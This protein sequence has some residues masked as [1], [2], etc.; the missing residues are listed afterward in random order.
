MPTGRRRAAIAVV[1][2]LAGALSAVPMLRHPAAAGPSAAVVGT[3]IADGQGFWIAASDGSVYTEGDAP[4]YGSAGG[5]RLSKPIVGMAATKDARGYWLVASDGG[6]FSFGDARFYGSTGAIRLNQPI[7]GMTATPDG[8]GYWLV[9]SDGGI[10]S[11][12]DA[13]FYGSTGAIRLNQPIVGMAADQA[14]GGYWMVASDGGIFA[15]H[16]PF[17]GST[18]STSPPHPI[19]GMAAIPDGG[20]YRF[21]ASDGGIFDFGD[22]GYYGSMTGSTIPSPIT[23]LADSPSGSGY[24]LVQRNGTSAS[25]GDAK[26]QSSAV[27]PQNIGPIDTHSTS[28][29]FEGRNPDGAPMRFDACQ[30]IHYVTNLAEAPLGAPAYVQSA[31]ARLSSATG[32]TFVNDGSST[33]FPSTSRSATA[34]SGQSWAPVLI[35]WEHEGQTDYLPAQANLLGMGGFTGVNTGGTVVAVTGQVALNADLRLVPGTTVPSTWVPGIQHELAHVVGLAHTS[36][37]TQIMAPS[38]NSQSPLDY[39]TGDLEGLSQLGAGSACLTAPAPASAADLARVPVGGPTAYGGIPVDR[40][41]G[42]GR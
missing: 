14:T 15:F 25:F 13:R 30:A 9:A 27:V 20:G 26:Y 24:V 10:F 36:D 34:A 28:Y 29:A 39:G 23:A 42:T 18:G 8:G 7:V 32:I 35:A 2:L 1:G 38:F 37:P 4:F 41:T 11:F 6:I 21:T 3:A 5:T 12:G 31:I 40:A 16:A 33:Q 19:V 22:A 17:L